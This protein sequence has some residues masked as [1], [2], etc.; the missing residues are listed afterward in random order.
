VGAMKLIHEIKKQQG[1]S[2]ASFPLYQ[3]VE[4]SQKY[5][6]PKGQEDMTPLRATRIFSCISDEVI[7]HL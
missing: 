1:E 5:V 4:I 3:G 2:S 7:N 6:L